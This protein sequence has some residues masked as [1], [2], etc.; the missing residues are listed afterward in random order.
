ML[1]KFAVPAVVVTAFFAGAAINL[2]HRAEAAEPR[3]QYGSAT[4]DPGSISDGAEA[5][6]EVSVLNARLGDFCSA[7]FSVDVADLA[8]VCAVTA[9][10]V[11]TVQLLNN[12]GGAIDLASGTVRVKI[13]RR[14]L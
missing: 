9:S 4:W 3:P 11:V 8:L 6:T 10:G 13:D 7:S 5:V 2:A 1:K 12:T 14:Q